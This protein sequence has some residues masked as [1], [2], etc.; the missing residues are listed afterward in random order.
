MSDFDEKP[1]FYQSKGK[2]EKIGVNDVNSLDNSG[3]D[4]RNRSGNPRVLVDL[5]RLIPN[6]SNENNFKKKKQ[7]VKNRR[8]GQRKW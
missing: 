3:S 7:L 6:Y 5:L 1:R 4:I 2:G 8:M